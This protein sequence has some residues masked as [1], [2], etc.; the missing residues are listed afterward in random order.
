M[1]DD[2]KKLRKARK[3][4]VMVALEKSV[5]AG[6]LG[7][8]VGTFFMCIYMLQMRRPLNLPL[9]IILFVNV[10]PVILT[11][12][13]RVLI[14]TEYRAIFP[15]LMKDYGFDRSRF[16][17]GVVGI[18]LSYVLLFFLKNEVTAYILIA[19]LIVQAAVFAYS[20]IEIR[21]RMLPI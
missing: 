16:L 9:Y 19:A 8:S 3:E 14:G 5:T 6:R 4:V 10:V 17:G 21:R 13:F 20:I 2:K 1:S 12:I 7:L 15:Q 11:L 18:I